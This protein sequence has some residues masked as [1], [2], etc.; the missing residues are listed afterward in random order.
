MLKKLLRAVLARCGVIGAPSRC[1]KYDETSPS[2]PYAFVAPFDGYCSVSIYGEGFWV[3]AM[4]STFVE[5][6]NTDAFNQGCVF[7]IRKGE[8]YNIHHSQSGD[9]RF[10]IHCYPLDNTE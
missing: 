9:E 6:Q 10:Q 3:S 5:M 1:I 2:N 7:P 8:T 4:D